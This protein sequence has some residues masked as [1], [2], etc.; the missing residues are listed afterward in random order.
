LL[1]SSLS[2][3]SRRITVLAIALA[4]TA[5]MI[6]GCASTPTASAPSSPASTVATAPPQSAPET[7]TAASDVQVCAECAGKGMPAKV[8]GTA[9]VKGGVQVVD[10]AIVNGTYAPNAITA[11]AGLPTQVVFTGKAKG[12]LAKPTFKALGKSGDVTA[13]GSATIDLGTLKPGVYKFTCAMG[14]NA[15]TITVQ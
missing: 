5:V 9:T 6:A 4:A 12:C 2:A 7:A 8:I 14:M 10:V 13:T 3:R 11:Q 1:L 15:A